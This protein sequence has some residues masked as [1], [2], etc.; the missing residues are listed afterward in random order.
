MLGRTHW[1]LLRKALHPQI[2]K[3]LRCRIH[4]RHEQM[5]P[6]TGARDIKQVPFGVVDFFKIR[7]IGDRLDTFLQ[8]N[9]LVIASRHASAPSAGR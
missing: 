5:V 7:V 4:A 3:E 6:R 2:V 9:D 1:L 8:R